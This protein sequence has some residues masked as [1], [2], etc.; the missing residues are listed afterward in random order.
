MRKWVFAFFVLNF[1]F[2]TASIS[3]TSPR[4]RE[5][6]GLSLWYSLIMSLALLLLSFWAW[7]D[8]DKM[9]DL[10]NDIEQLYG[11]IRKLTQEE[12]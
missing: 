10:N 3:T 7:K 4:V 11:Y 12:K 6:L 5:L 2:V 8:E 9:K 1:I